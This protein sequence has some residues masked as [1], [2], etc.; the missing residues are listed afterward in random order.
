MLM[1]PQKVNLGE[2]NRNMAGHSGS[3][4]G[5]AADEYADIENVDDSYHQTIDE[6]QNLQRSSR[7]NTN[8]KERNPTGTRGAAVGGTDSEP[9][10]GL[11][12]RLSKVP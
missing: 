5:H 10:S 2:K 6:M 12:P 8:S 7:G 1:Q 4:Y 11:S 9:D 3:K